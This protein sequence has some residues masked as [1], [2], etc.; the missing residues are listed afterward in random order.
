MNKAITEG[1]ALMPPPFAQGLGTWSS[2][3]GTQGSDTY[4]GASNAVF[5]PSDSDFGGCLEMLK[6]Q[7][8]QRLRNMAQTPIFPGCYLRITARVKAISG[9]RPTVRIAGYAATAGGAHV[10]GLT[11][12]GPSTV[13][14]GYGSVVEV[15]AI[16]GSGVRGGVDMVWGATP[17]YGHFGLDL[18]GASGGVVRIDDIVIEDITS[19]FH[20]D[21]MNWVDVRDFGAVGDGSTDNATAFEAA[22]AAADGKRVLV[23]EGVYYLGDSVTFQNPV[24]FEGTVTMGVGSIFSLTKNFDLPSYINAFGDEEMAFKKAFQSLLNNSDH[25]SLDLGGRRITITEPIDLQAA[26]PNRGSY[27]QRRHIANGQFYV[28]GDSAWQPDVVTSQATYSP[29]EGRTLRNV[30]NVANIQVG[31]LVTGNGVGREVYVREVDIPT[32]EVTLS[33]PLYDAAGTQNFTFTRFKYILDFSGFSKV[34]AFSISD[35]ELQCNSKANGI[36]LSPSGVAFHFRDSYITRPKHRGISSCGEGCQGLLVDR[37]QFITN[38]G[39]TPSQD[40][41]SVAINCNANDF[42]LRNNRASQFRHFAV[43]GGENAMVTGN[44]FFQGDDE[45]DGVRTA[46]IVFAQGFISATF[47]G[48]YVDNCFLEWSNEYDSEPDF[49]GGFSFGSLSIT[50]N[51]FLSGDVA[52]WFGYIVIKPHG[53]DHFITGLNVTGNKFR[54]IN[55][56]IDRVD[57]VDTSFSNLDMSK[58]KNILFAGNT[59][60]NVVTAAHSPL[61]VKHDQNT[62]QSTW[63]VRTEGK[64]PFGGR[65][66]GVDALVPTSKLKNTSNVTVY[67][68][69]NVLLE[70]GSDGSEVDLRWANN[71]AGDMTVV[72]RMD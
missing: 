26:V 71:Y 40:R 66:R 59:F 20:R 29:S 44:H 46:G 61:R 67:D 9:N 64:L 25:E 52:P 36:L 53:A 8:T 48:N 57:R 54:S 35:V 16:V 56:T 69:P 24:E 51:V 10:N 70:Q 15:S 43:I 6:T 34:S 45:P 41:V 72:V 50:D 68:M 39:G 22:D 42:K 33:Q 23:P 3:D 31:S 28:T 63:T 60:H 47:D 62:H 32:Q 38:E 7:S 13:L 19:A 30:V 14:T 58:G 2:G 49:T 21:M 12:V 27:A 65:A 18:T 55:G 17:A 37:C 11:E 5:V 1:L 4:A